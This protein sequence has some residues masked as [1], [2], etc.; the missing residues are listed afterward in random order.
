MARALLNAARVTVGVGCDYFLS[1]GAIPDRASNPR[2]DMKTVSAPTPLVNRGR[3]VVALLVG[4]CLILA[5]GFSACT[6]KRIPPPPKDTLG[7]LDPVSEG[8]KVDLFFD[9]TLSMKGFVT[10]QSTTAYQLLVPMLERS[11][12]EGWKGG[13]VTFYK[14]GDDIAPL[15]SRTYLDAVK[16][17]FYGDSR[18]NRKTLIERVIDKASTDHLTVIITDLFQTNADINQLSEKVKEKFIAQNVSVGVYAIRSQFAGAIYDVGPN[19][20]SFTYAAKPN[21]GRPFYLLTFGK[22]SDVAHYFSVL[23]SSGL[24]DVVDKHK[25]VFSRYL[26]TRPLAFASARLKTADKISEIS[27]SNLLTGFS[28]DSRVKTFKITKGKTI[29]KFSADL[30][31][32]SQLGDVMEYGSALALEITAWKGEDKGGKE[33]VESENSQA[34][35]AFHVDI[36]LTPDEFPFTNVKLQTSVDVTALPGAGVY[37][38]RILLRPNHYMLPEWVPNW[39]MRDEDIARWHRDSKDFNGTRTYNLE[40]F[41]GTLQGAVLR[42]TPPKVG[43]LYCYI[44]VDK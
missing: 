10:A 28:D 38:Y 41:L 15:P 8:L 23:D 25:L 36:K 22:H 35:K 18:L 9:A 42:T 19:G 30:P 11:V 21:E 43:E 29:A 26:T 5:T 4:V 16:E 17:T 24:K 34:L 40:N 2:A 12:I 27:P 7:T 37:C 44:Q 13:E 6:R 31:Y 32:D 20:Y 14:F 33:L 39:N 3:F 1:L